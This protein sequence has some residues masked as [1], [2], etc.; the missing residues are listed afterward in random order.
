MKRG[1]G[2]CGGDIYVVCVIRRVWLRVGRLMITWCRMWGDGLKTRFWTDLKLE[3][4]VE[5]YV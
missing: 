4:G 3:G 1:L 2:L 5:G